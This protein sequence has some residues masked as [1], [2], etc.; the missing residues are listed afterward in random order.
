MLQSPHGSRGNPTPAAP[1]FSPVFVQVPRTSAARRGMTRKAR[2]TLLRQMNERTIFEIVRARGPISRAELARRSGMSAPTASKVVAN[3]LET[4]LLEETG[5]AQPAKAGRPGRLYRLGTGA[6]QVLGAVIDV[7]KSCV[8]S[9]SLDGQIHQHLATEFPTPDTYPELIG[10][11]ASGARKLMRRGDVATL[12]L[13]IS[14]P[15]ELDRRNQRVVLSPNLHMIDG[16]S[17]SADLR[18]KLGVP[19]VM[20]HETVGT[21]LAE[22]AYGAARG[23]QD[24]VMIGTYE[25]FGVSIVSGGRLVEGTDGMASEM[26]HITVDLHGEP[27]GCGNRGCLETVATDPAFARR[28]SKRLGRPV[29]VEEAVRLVHDGKVAAADD[30]AITLDYLSVGVAAAINIFNPEAVLLC[31]RLLDLGPE[32]MSVLRA[33]VAARALPPLMRSCQIL[34]AEGNTRKGAI[35]AIVHHLTHALGPALD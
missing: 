17:P 19:S 2:P 14:T 25:G 10:A 8:V 3:L 31:S 27:C 21:C 32:T 4:G 34:R 18:R 7:R 29:E 26:G 35:A 5:A 28:I 22:Q 1:G 16:R 13:G 24:F 23:M 33:K 12:G 15:G 30:V 20:F 11:L 6:V 9:A